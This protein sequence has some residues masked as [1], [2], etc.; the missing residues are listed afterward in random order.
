MYGF[1]GMDEAKH[2]IQLPPL[3]AFRAAEALRGI[4]IPEAKW[5]PKDKYAGR[6]KLRLKINQ[7]A[8]I[9]AM[10]HANQIPLC[11]LPWRNDLPTR[12][13][14]KRNRKVCTI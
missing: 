9:V 4:I 10:L 14:K 2:T 7:D 8:K 6:W 3:A 12:I 11:P 13:L 1:G 5:E